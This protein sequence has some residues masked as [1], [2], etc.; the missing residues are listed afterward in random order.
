MRN[1]FATYLLVAVSLTC[2]AADKAADDTK[3][4]TEADTVLAIYVRNLGLA[5]S[6]K[7]ELVIGIWGDGQV[8]WSEDRVYG[9]APYRSGTVDP[10]QV[11]A[12]IAR[13]RKDGVFDNEKLARS[14]FGP[15]SKFT[16]IL[17]KSGKQQLKM[18]SW[19][20]LAEDSGKT[21]ATSAGISSLNGRRRYDVLANDK[22]EYLHYRLVWAE[23]R[24][25]IATL[26]PDTSTP[27]NGELLIKSGK[28]S[29][30]E[31]VKE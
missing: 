2:D 11:A 13:L 9:G 26:I 30:H 16:S 15:D 18:E 3:P 14:N 10:K 20:E 25:S 5:S 17:I 27:D 6:G 7:P 31:L 24:A 1:M 29:W 4:V 8:V 19:H 23:I 12:L 28:I 21:V 22:A